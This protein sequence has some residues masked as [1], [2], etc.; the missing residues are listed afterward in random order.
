MDSLEDLETRSICI[1][2]EAFHRFQP[3]GFLWSMG[4]DSTV[5][6]H[7]IRKAFLGRFPFPAVHLDTGYKLPAIYEFRDR[8]AA[9]WNVPLLVVRPEAALK[10]GVGPETSGRLAC[11]TQLKTEA[12]KQCLA[13]RGF[14]AIILGIRRDEHGVRAKERYFS[15]RLSD[16]TWNAERQPAELWDLY[17]RRAREG[18]HVRIHPLLHFTEIDIWRYIERESLPVCDLYFSRGGKRYR[19]IG[20]APC[21]EPVSSTASTVAQIIEELVEGNDE[22]RGGRAQDKEA[23]RAMEQLRALGY[24]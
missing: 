17:V 7:L 8:L 3:L 19:S 13:A 4:K 6:L 9:A 2:R 22:E 11:C 15:L 16:F 21:C 18:A 1:I 20:C 14:R 12:L 24:M 10:A 5:L 23:V